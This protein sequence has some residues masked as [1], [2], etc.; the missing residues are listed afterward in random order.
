[1]RQKKLRI[2]A[3][4]AHLDDI[5]IACGG[6]LAKAVDKGHEVKMLVL[7]KS[8]YVHYKGKS[9]RTENIAVKEAR[10]AASILGVNDL[11]ILEF[12][13]KDIPYESQVVES[14]NARLDEFRPNLIIT[15]WPFDTHKSHQNTALSAIAAGRYYNSIIMFEPFPPGGRSYVGFRPQLYVDIT[16]Y[17]DAKINSIKAHKSEFEKY[18]GKNWIDA[19]KARAIFRG[20]DLIAPTVKTPKY[21][22]AFE[23]IRLNIDFLS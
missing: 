1:M 12:P 6:T 3:I 17:I 21:A 23:I 19:I 7:S 15:H 22:E 14:I 10:L 4:G 20:F 5:E 11:E 13:T 18:G 8:A 16:I 2:M 9:I